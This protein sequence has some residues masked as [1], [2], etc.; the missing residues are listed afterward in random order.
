MHAMD[1]GWYE[2]FHQELEA[3]DKE[4]IEV[5]GKQLKPSQ[6]YHIGVDPTHILFNTNCPSGL[7]DKINEILERYHFK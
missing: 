6:C 3:L 7:R 4:T 1:P 5:D 2:Q